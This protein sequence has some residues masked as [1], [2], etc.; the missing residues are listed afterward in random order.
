MITLALQAG[1]GWSVFWASFPLLVSSLTWTV[2]T[3][4]VTHLDWSLRRI[5]TR[6]DLDRGG[7]HAGDG[8][9]RL[10]RPRDRDRLRRSRASAWASRARRCS[11]RRS[12]TTPGREGRDTSAVTTA[13][14]LGAGIGAALAGFV[15]LETVPHSVLRAAENGVAPLPKLHDAAGLAFGLLG[16]I[17]LLSLPATRGIRVTP[18]RSR[19][20]E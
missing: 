17:V 9:P 20:V 16:L 15:L 8:D 10:Q 13:R 1:S 2:A 14:Q 19:P 11:P 5:V 3:G 6:R 12:P 18:R 4:L 7:R